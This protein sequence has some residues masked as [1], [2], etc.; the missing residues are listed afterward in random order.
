M[1]GIILYI[2]SIIVFI[3]ILSAQPLNGKGIQL[4]PV[5]KYQLVHYHRITIL[6]N[7]IILASQTLFHFLYGIVP[8][9]TNNNKTSPFIHNQHHLP[10]QTLQLISTVRKTPRSKKTVSAMIYFSSML[11]KKGGQGSLS[12]GHTSEKLF[13]LEQ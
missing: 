2:V 1:R 6:I 4:V 5:Y 12:S 9:F 11:Q 3:W 10:S 7:I 8:L 13:S